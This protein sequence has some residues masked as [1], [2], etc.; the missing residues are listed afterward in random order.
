MRF[1]PYEALKGQLA[2]AT[3]PMQ[4]SFSA[5]MISY[6]S[7]SPNDMRSTL[8]SFPLQLKSVREHAREVVMA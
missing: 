4:R 2:P 6:A 7:T 8:K 3:D 5:R 1:V